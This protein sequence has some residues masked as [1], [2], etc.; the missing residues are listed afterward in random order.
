MPFSISDF[1]SLSR[2]N[3]AGCRGPMLRGPARLS[4]LLKI[5][6]ESRMSPGMPRVYTKYFRE[7]DKTFR[8]LAIFLG[9][10]PKIPAHRNI[11]RIIS[12]L[13]LESTVEG[14]FGP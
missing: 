4:G 11:A 14:E 6:R 3:H 13:Q 9:P 7:P 10:E 5:I 8:E 1:A 12:G 2:G